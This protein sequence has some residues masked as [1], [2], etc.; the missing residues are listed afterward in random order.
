MIEKNTRLQE[1]RSKSESAGHGGYNNLN[2]SVDE[3]AKED[4][5]HVMSTVQG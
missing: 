2:V 5:V 1:E 4:D 3:E